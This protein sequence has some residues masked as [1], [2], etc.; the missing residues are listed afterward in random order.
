MEKCRYLLVRFAALAIPMALIWLGAA[1]SAEA[2]PDPPFKPV[3]TLIQAFGLPGPQAPGFMPELIFAMSADGRVI[4]QNVRPE[5]L[6]QVPP[7]FMRVRLSPI[8]RAA[9]WN[10]ALPRF[11]ELDPCAGPCAPE[12]GPR[13]MI[14][15]GAP[16]LLQLTSE[17]GVIQKARSYGDLW[18]PLPKDTHIAPTFIA[19]FNR[20]AH[21]SHPGAVAWHATRLHVRIAAGEKSEFY[22]PLEWPKTLTTPTSQDAIVCM[23]IPPG[24][25]Q[26][27]LEMRALQNGN[28]L[29]FEGRAWRMRDYWYELPFGAT[30]DDFTDYHPWGPPLSDDC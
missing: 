3:L 29:A 28:G 15:D 4:F 17:D 21:F 11:R 7:R 20:L 22:E 19:M 2:E 5:E 9:L 13:V 30:P 16:A 10:E 25:L 6:G 27:S 18:H 14:W 1:R 23:P 26:P 24:G 8:E 12:T